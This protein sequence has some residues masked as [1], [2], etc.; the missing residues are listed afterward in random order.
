MTRNSCCA[1]STPPEEGG[2]GP[3][4]YDMLQAPLQA[5]MDEH[6]IHQRGDKLFSG[7]EEFL[8]R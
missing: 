2:G 4:H 1:C 7:R 3:S 6:M 8:R 5:L